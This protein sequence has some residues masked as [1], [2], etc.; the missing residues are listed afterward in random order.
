MIHFD[1]QL[2]GGRGAKIRARKKSRFKALKNKKPE[3]QDATADNSANLFKNKA[4][5]LDPVEK[6]V[7]IRLDTSF[8]LFNKKR[9]VIY[10]DIPKHDSNLRSLL[11]DYHR[12]G[13]IDV[14][15]HLGV[16]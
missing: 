15:H 1:L 11:E 3:K 8:E 7:N 14:T 6:L 2:L 12:Q 4:D 10:T 16:R 5:F 9:N 13:K